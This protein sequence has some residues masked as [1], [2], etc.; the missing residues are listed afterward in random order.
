MADISRRTALKSGALLAAGASSIL[1][2]SR[3]VCVADGTGAR[4]G[5]GDAEA[6]GD[7]YYKR[8]TTIIESVRRTEMERIGDLTSRMADTIKSGGEV[9]LQAAEGHMGRF[10]NDETLPGNPGVIRSLK[11]HE[12]NKVEKVK[13]AA[14]KKGDILVTN[15]VNAAIREARDR[16]VHVVGLPVNYVDNEWTPRGFVS[17]NE[18]GWL[19]GDVTS[20]IIQSYVPYTQGI[21]DCPQIPEMKL[22]PSSSNS[23]YTLYWMF[24]CE[25][26]DKVKNSSA[27]HVGA[28]LAV[29]DTVLERIH[30]AVRSQ[31]EYIYDHAPTV[32]KR[33]GGGAHFHVSSD[34]K[35]VQEESNRVANGPMMTNAFRR[36]VRFDGAVMGEDQMKKGDVHLFAVNEADAPPIVEEA[37]KARDMDMFIVTIAPAASYELRRLSDVFIDNLCPEGAGLLD[38][39]G[40]PKKVGSIGSIVNNTLMWIFTAQFIDEMVRRGWIPWFYLGYY[41]VGG[42]PYDTA[43]KPFF[44]KQGF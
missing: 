6:L 39:K 17:P 3:H 29:I 40:Y 41:Q 36:I 25:T 35:S 20:E 9:W 11:M 4:H 14:L 24:Q 27:K 28:S 15:H 32:A 30:E 21:V 33:I 37:R 42:G 7:Q 38:I 16:G 43:V 8:M 12:W 44:L 13:C 26:A 19:L 5:F 18:N 10:E 22:F 34:P 2:G 23:L 1:T 31:R